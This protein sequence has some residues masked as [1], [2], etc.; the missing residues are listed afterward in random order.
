MNDYPKANEDGTPY[1]ACCVSEIDA[2]NCNHLRAQDGRP[3][4]PDNNQQ[5]NGYNRNS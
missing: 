4:K 3:L 1:W 5:Y 2:G